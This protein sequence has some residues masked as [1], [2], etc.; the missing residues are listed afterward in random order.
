VTGTVGRAA[1]WV[2]RGLWV[3]ITVQLAAMVGGES[4]DPA[5]QR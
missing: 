4:A 5:D 2:L 1:R 3:T